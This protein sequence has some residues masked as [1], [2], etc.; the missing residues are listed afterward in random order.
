VKAESLAVVNSKTYQAL[1]QERAEMAAERQKLQAERAQLELFQ[2]DVEAQ[3]DAVRK[4]REKIE[5]LVSRSD[6]LEKKKT[7]QLSK[8]YA[9]MR[10]AEAAQI[11]STL[12]DEL[13]AKIIDGIGDDRQ[14][15]KIL[16]LLP[17]DKATRMTQLMGGGKR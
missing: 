12:Q 11:I 4:E 5:G 3:K 14:K 15:A 6:S 8:T 13:A 10:P 16:A 2:R 9:A 17:G 7:A 1:Q